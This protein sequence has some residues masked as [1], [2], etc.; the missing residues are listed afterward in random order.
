MKA[1]SSTSWSS[2]RLMS[3]TCG[4]KSA[5]TTRGSATA[6]SP[7]PRAHGSPHTATS[8]SRVGPAA[9]AAPGGLRAPPDAAVAAEAGQ[10]RGG[11]TS[12]AGRRG[13]PLNGDRRAQERPAVRLALAPDP[14]D[15][16]PSG[17]YCRTWGD[18]RAGQGRPTPTR[19]AERREGARVRHA[20]PAGHPRTHPISSMPIP[21]Y[22]AVT[23]VVPAL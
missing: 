2:D 17:S 13:Q 10:G 12:P 18:G 5:A 15:R 22:R 9:A 3:S 11:G 21:G 19:R 6:S 20:A 7:P 23:A 4:R 14:P 16:H 1:R 8:T